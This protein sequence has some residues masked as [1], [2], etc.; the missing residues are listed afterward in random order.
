[1][2]VKPPVGRAG[3]IQLKNDAYMQDR[4]RPLLTSCWRKELC[5]HPCGT[6]MGLLQHAENRDRGSGGNSTSSQ[7]SALQH[8]ETLEPGVSRTLCLLWQLCCE[9]ELHCWGMQPWDVLLDSLPLEMG[10]EVPFLA[11]Q[12]L[13]L[14]VRPALLPG[15][16]LLLSRANT[17]A[18]VLEEA[19]VPLALCESLAGA[20]PLECLLPCFFLDVQA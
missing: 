19:Q 11:N 10:E 16:Q 7:S 15:L 9:T 18:Q 8:P 6:D 17:L 14:C 4:H 2:Q 12:H 13:A 5:S 1:M 3:E 20:Q